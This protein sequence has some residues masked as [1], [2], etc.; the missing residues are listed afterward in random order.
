[1]FT[2]VKNWYFGYKVCKRY[3]LKF[4]PIMTSKVNGCYYSQLGCIRVALFNINFNEILFHELGHHIDISQSSATMGSVFR[5]LGTDKSLGEH[6]YNI[7]LYREGRASRY[8]MRFL[9]STGLNVDNSFEFLREA[10]TTYIR[11]IPSSQLPFKIM[12]A[13]LDYK[14]C[15]YIKG[16]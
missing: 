8:A 16:C 10:I 15:R 7:T 1:M 9:R 5:I 14:L 6:S 11:C 3:K 12:L 13:D 2:W 4:K